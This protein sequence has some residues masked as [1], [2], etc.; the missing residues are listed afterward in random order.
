MMSRTVLLLS[1]L[2][3]LALICAVWQF[4]GAKFG[5][6]EF[7]TSRTV[8]YTSPNCVECQ[9][10]ETWLTEVNFQFER[11]E[12][13]TP[14]AQSELQKAAAHCQL[15]TDQGILLP[16]LFSGGNCYVGMT[17]IQAYLKPKYL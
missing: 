5:T 3:I 13:T 6:S 12:V 10:T 17:A 16:I 1:L 8:F 15:N 14:V 9:T 7:D 11:T 4:S 2:A